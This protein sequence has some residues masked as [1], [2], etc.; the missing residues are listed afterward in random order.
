MNDTF[1]VGRPAGGVAG[2]ARS[3]HFR[4][5][6]AVGRARDAR[7]QIVYERVYVLFPF[8]GELPRHVLLVIGLTPYGCLVPGLQ[9][10]RSSVSG[11]GASK[12]QRDFPRVTAPRREAA[13]KRSLVRDRSCLRVD[14]APRVFLVGSL[15]LLL[16]RSR[17]AGC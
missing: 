13:N 10:G 9:S 17:A 1:R 6:E 16:C 3:G 14:R 11:E 15:R 2:R 12:P 4:L 8:S 5:E 7:R